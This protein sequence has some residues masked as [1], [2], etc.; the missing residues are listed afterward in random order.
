MADNQRSTIVII[1]NDLDIQEMIAFNF[2]QEGYRV[3]CSMTGEDGLQKIRSK[4][5][6]IVLL[7][8]MLPGMS[9]IEVCKAIREDDEIKQTKI[10]MLTAKSEEANMILGLEIGADDY[11]TKPFSTKVLLAK[12]NSIVRREHVLEQP[13]KQEED[14]DLG[15]IQVQPGRRQVIINNDYIKLTTSEF[16]AFKL[17]AQKPDW[18]VSRTQIVEAIHGPGHVVSNRAIDVMMVSLRKKLGKYANYIETI[19]GVGYCLRLKSDIKSES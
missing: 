14:I 6:N 5:P 3:F 13:Q 7:D 12:I 19:R 2:R 10:V 16:C 8:W 9:G 17:L 11:M 1:E 18:V 15:I 4:K